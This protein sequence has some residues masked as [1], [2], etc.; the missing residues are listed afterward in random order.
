MA[1]DE[2]RVRSRRR[3]SAPP[4]RS[5]GRT[6][7]PAPLGGRRLARP[8]CAARATGRSRRPAPHAA[9]TARARGRAP[10]AAAGPEQLRRHR[11][12]LV[13]MLAGGRAGCSCRARGDRASSTCRRCSSDHYAAL[14]VD[15]RSARKLAA[16]RGIIF[17]RNGHDLALSVPQQT[18]WA[19]PRVVNDP[20]ELRGAARA[21]RR[22][23]PGELATRLAQTDKAFVYVARKV[24]TRPRCRVAALELAGVGLVPETKRYYPAGARRAGARLRRHRQRRSRRARVA[25]RGRAWPGARGARRRA[26]PHR[27]R[28]PRR[29]RAG[30]R[31]RA[32]WPTSC[33]RSTSR[34]STRPSGARRGGRPRSK[35]KG[36]WRS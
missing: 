20:A 28:A 34:S 25:V 16:E 11:R 31:G 33:S 23:R 4:D 32:R 10:G 26:R 22:R 15:Q 3:A 7:T 21:A 12:R 1:L 17:D 13:G 29:Q 36:G 2:A 19:D 6:R 14:G 35:A 5:A 27:P 9:P 18:V 8:A 30:R 24:E